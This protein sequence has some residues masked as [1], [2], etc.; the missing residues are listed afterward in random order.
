[1]TFGVSL[2]DPEAGIKGFYKAL[3]IH[4]EQKVNLTFTTKRKK[5]L[6][7]RLQNP[8]ENKRKLT[9]VAFKKSQDL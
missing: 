5:I 4:S 6:P 7:K 1:M 3:C 8:K 9:F 2:K